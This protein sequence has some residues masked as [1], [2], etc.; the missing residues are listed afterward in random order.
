L[1]EIIRKSVLSR[2]IPGLDDADKLHLTKKKLPHGKAKVINDISESYKHIIE[3]LFAEKWPKLKINQIS[4][5]VSEMVMNAILH[6][7]LC[8]ENYEIDISYILNGEL[9]EI[10]VSDEGLGF[11]GNKVA[12]SITEKDVLKPHGRGLHM[13]ELFAEE[14]YFSQSGNKCWAI[15]RREGKSLGAEIQGNV[16]F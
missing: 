6:G 13:V 3:E 14:M 16:I 5:A 1:L 7:N 8:Q 9:L 4:M 10:C 11:D 12:Q 15:F 2:K